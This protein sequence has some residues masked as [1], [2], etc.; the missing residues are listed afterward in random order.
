MLT[1]HLWYRNEI[2]IKNICKQLDDWQAPETK[3]FIFNVGTF[4]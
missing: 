1:K 4:L 3:R 2:D